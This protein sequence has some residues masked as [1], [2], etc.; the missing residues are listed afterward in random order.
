M[1]ASRGVAFAERSGLKPAVTAGHG[2]AGVPTIANPLTFSATAPRYDLPPPALDE[3]GEQIRAW[4]AGP[5]AG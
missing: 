4:L 5:A 2:A 3:H 1:A